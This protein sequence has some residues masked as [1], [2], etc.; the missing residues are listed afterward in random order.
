MDGLEATRRV[1]QAHP[2]GRPR[3]VAMTANAMQGDREA[4]LAAGMDDYITKPV[5][6][7]ELVAALRRSA[8]ALGRAGAE[9]AAG[10]ALAP[11]EPDG[12]PGAALDPAPLER[13]RM[14][15]GEADALAELIQDQLDESRSLVDR[16]Q[17][18][19]EAGDAATLERAAHSLKSSAAMF[20]ALALSRL[21]AELESASRGA[22]AEGARATLSALLVEHERARVALEEERRTLRS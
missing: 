16:M 6:I 7:G 5:Q 14:L 8:A 21:C 20:G 17:A 15:T 2:D 12:E 18:A 9:D 11:E 4:C 1:R 3:I 10:A 19:L 22:I 13:L